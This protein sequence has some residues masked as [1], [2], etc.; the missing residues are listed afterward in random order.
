MKR[1]VVALDFSQPEQAL[2]FARTLTPESCRLKVGK[3]LFTRGGPGLIKQLHALGFELFLD[4]KFHDIPNTVA[5][6]V[7]ASAELGVWMVNVHASGG[8]KMMSAA[9]HALAEF[10]EKAPLLIGV[11]VLTSMSDEDLHSTGI[12]RSLEE[13]VLFL[14]KQ[15]QSAGLDGVVCSAREAEMLRREL[16]PD[17]LLVTPGIRPKGAALDDQTRV[18]TPEE[19]VI[20]GVDYLVM[21]RPIRL[22]DQ[23]VELL[24]AINQQLAALPQSQG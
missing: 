23:P 14:A 13:Q 3:E 8:A 20:S 9:K 22:N 11:T 1:I 2:D 16:G 18:M 5:Q 4:L 10:G 7:K 12:T 15:A 24:S 6:A 17:F 21:G 19:A